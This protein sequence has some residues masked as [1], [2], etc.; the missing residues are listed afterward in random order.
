MG[1][2]A[3]SEDETFIEQQLEN[4]F[5]F[6]DFSSMHQKSKM[7]IDGWLSKS[8]E[9]HYDDK[10]N[11]NDITSSSNTTSNQ[12]HGYTNNISSN[13]RNNNFNSSSFTS[14]F[15]KQNSKFEADFETQSITLEFN[16]DTVS[17]SNYLNNSANLSR[18]EPRTEARVFA[19]FNF[20]SNTQSSNPKIPEIIINEHKFKIPSNGSN[21]DKD[22]SSTN[23]FESSTKPLQTSASSKPNYAIPSPPPLPHQFNQKQGLLKF[24]K[25]NELNNSD[26]YANS[27]SKE[28]KKKS[29]Q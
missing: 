26:E 12:K 13:T 6:P 10:E 25:T 5:G 3:E 18:S 21:I 1:E 17:N 29:L 4:D 27:L 20:N 11:E 14:M 7:K 9:L 15:E 19:N 8:A 28:L 22:V 16:D 23:R 24:K 2:S